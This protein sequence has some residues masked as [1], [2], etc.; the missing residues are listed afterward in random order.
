MDS[1]LLNS[2][3]LNPSALKLG[4]GCARKDVRRLQLIDFLDKAAPPVASDWYGDQAAWG[5]MLNDTLGDC[6]IAAPGHGIQVV[7]RNTPDGEVTPPDSAIEDTYE[8][9]CGY[10]PG[11]PS[12][13]QGGDIPTVLNYIR[14]NGLAG[15]KLYAYADPNPNDIAHVKQAIAEFGVVDIGLQLPLSAQSQVGALWDIVGDPT[16]D[17][18]SLPGSWGGHSVICGKYDAS[19]I[20]CITWGGVQPM[21]WRFFLTYVDE[22]HALLFRAWM[23]RFGAQSAVNLP[24]MEAALQLVTA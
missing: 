18:N 20:S 19:T 9:A 21:T 13:D 12:T 16:K 15:H 5:E 23:E 3:L 8:K 4:K 17:P 2:W 11:D 22:V 14:K 24:K 7:T 1:R 10:V 6:T